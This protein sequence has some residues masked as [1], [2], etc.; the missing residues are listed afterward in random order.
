MPAKGV[1]S[2]PDIGRLSGWHA[3]RLTVSSVAAI[4]EAVA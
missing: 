1:P 2:L 4:A 3:E